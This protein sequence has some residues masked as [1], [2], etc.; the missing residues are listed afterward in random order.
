MRSVEVGLR[1][2]QRPTAAELGCEPLQL[3]PVQGSV[4]NEKIYV[5][6]QDRGP[7]QD[8]RDVPDD[9]SVKADFSQRCRQFGEEFFFA[10]LEA[11]STVFSEM[12]EEPP[13]AARKTTEPLDDQIEVFGI[14]TDYR[15]ADLGA[16]RAHAPNKCLGVAGPP[17]PRPVAA[18]S[19]A[20]R[21][22]LAFPSSPACF[23]N[24]HRPM[25]PRAWVLSMKLRL[26]QPRPW[27]P[28]FT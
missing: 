1:D 27:S 26:T 10:C 7:V 20:L 5:L 15:G 16:H 11:I 3:F 13:P 17:A 28:Q 9:D 21:R 2:G 8:A 12:D 18:S 6:G 22:T 25:I 19:F 23:T 24:V 14:D 4:A